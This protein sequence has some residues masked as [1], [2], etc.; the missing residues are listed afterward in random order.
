[1]RIIFLILAFMAL[2][3]GKK[4]KETNSAAPQIVTQPATRNAFLDV[5]PDGSLITSYEGRR[6]A[7]ILQYS[8]DDYLTYVNRLNYELERKQ[9]PLIDTDNEVFLE[10]VFLNG[11]I[12]SDFV[13]VEIND[14]LHRYCLPCDLGWNYFDYGIYEVTSEE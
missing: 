13:G 2:G 1:M 9:L 6:L 12:G 14:G 4:I 10:E 8:N 7:N 3:C 11:I 5:E